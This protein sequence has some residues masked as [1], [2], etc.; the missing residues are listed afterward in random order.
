MATRDNVVDLPGVQPLPENPMQ[1]APHMP[2]FC[3]HDYIVLD[4]HHRTVICADPKCGRVL[5]PFDFLLHNAY[6]ISRAWQTHREVTRSASELVERVDKLK[7]E[8]RRL[9]DMVKRLQTKVPVR[10]VRGEL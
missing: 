10:H 5:D 3:S 6:Q 8:E 9:R 4:E 7:R 2:G 1:V